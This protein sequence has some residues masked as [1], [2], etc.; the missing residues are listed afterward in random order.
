MVRWDNSLHPDDSQKLTPVKGSVKKTGS[1]SQKRRGSPMKAKGGLGMHLF[2]GG[3]LWLY[4]LKRARVFQAHV[5][6]RARVFQVHVL[7][8]TAAVQPGVECR[9]AY[10]TMK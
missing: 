8:R 2:T 10:D 6:K 4:V 3:V 5:L 9:S 1:H 7:K